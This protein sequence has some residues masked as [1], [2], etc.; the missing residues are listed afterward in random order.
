MHAFSAFE[1]FSAGAR[2]DASDDEAPNDANDNGARAKAKDDEATGASASDAAPPVPE[3]LARIAAQL[4]VLYDEALNADREEE[5]RAY[6]QAF[7]VLRDETR[8][9]RITFGGP[10]PVLRKVP[11]LPPPPSLVRRLPPHLRPRDA[12]PPA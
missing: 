2:P 3:M 6:A 7:N 4:L 10:P 8:G 5:A 11:R 9:V 12:T 1:S